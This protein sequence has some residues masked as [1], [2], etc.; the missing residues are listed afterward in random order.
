M[1]FI[2]HNST[3]SFVYS[4]LRYFVEQKLFSFQ[5]HNCDPNLFMLALHM[6]EKWIFPAIKILSRH[7]GK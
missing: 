1:I 6:K 5:L 4:R 2:S 3:I 7:L